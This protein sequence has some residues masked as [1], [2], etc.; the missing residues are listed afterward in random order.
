MYK[1][2]QPLIQEQEKQEGKK[3]CSGDGEEGTESS[4]ITGSGAIQKQADR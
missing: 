2:C 1:L 4:L 3:D